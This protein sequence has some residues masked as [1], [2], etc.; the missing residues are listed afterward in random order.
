MRY[1]TPSVRLPPRRDD[2][3][4]S[5]G[6]FMPA[7]AF[8]ERPQYDY[9]KSRCRGGLAGIHAARSFSTYLC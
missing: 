2:A 8:G 4:E 9:S 5:I 1:G 7:G 3:D 6:S